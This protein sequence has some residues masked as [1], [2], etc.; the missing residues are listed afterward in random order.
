MTTD[1]EVWA[2]VEGFPDYAV[3]THG[4]VM[5]VRTNVVL[6]PRLNSYGYSR[7]VL[8]RDGQSHD[9]FVHTLVARA[10]ITG[11]RWGVKITHVGDNSDNH[12]T[13][14]RF[15]RRFGKEVR[16]GVI[17]KHAKRA[18]ARRVKIV[19]TGMVFTSVE[20]CARYINGDTSTI[21]RVLKGLRDSH[22]GFT[23][24]Y[25]YEEQ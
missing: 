7:V 20:S 2:E 12:V 11:Y 19:E 9:F 24:E 21:Y 14:L 8:R 5:N 4:N 18:R 13:N 17:D 16:L 6:K 3:S 1:E 23:F 25:Q 10:F 15:L 22:K